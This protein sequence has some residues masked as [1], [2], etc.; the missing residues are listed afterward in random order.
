MNDPLVSVLIITYNQQETIRQAVESALAQTAPFPVEVVIGDDCSTDGTGAI[1]DALQR[2][3]PGRVNVVRPASNGG[4]HANFRQTL[5]ACR[6]E[7]VAILEGDDY[8]VDPEKLADQVT[9]LESSGVDIAFS[10]GFILSGADCRLA[11]TEFG[12][13]ARIV[14]LKDILD[15]PGIP[16]PTASILGRRSRLAAL[17]EW[18]N[19]APVLDIFLIMFLTADKGAAYLP[20]P[21]TVYRHGSTGSWTQAQR[22]QDWD[23]R[24]VQATRFLRSYARAASEWHIRPALLQKRLSVFHWTLARAALHRRQPVAAFSAAAKCR[25]AYLADRALR[26]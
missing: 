8:W 2:E 12:D 6:G 1:V 3:H 13:D 26:R 19:E 24:A 5:N 23:A 9:S 16:F 15:Q 22:R 7:Y 14:T 18:I 25:L 4:F 10:Q 21:T 17:P 20:R 11:W